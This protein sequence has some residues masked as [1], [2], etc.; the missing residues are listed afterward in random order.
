MLSVFVF[1]GD[2]DTA[3]GTATDPTKQNFTV[4]FR[5]IRFLLYLRSKRHAPYKK[6]G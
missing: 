5:R 3:I 1:C 4:G 6:R 2:P